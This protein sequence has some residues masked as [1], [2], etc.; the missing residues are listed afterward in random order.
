MVEVH[1]RCQFGEKR[2]SKGKLIRSGK[3]P[4]RASG[5]FRVHPVRGKPKVMFLCAECGFDKMPNHV[6]VVMP[7]ADAPPKAEPKY[8][9]DIERV[10]LL[11]TLGTKFDQA[12]VVKGDGYKHWVERTEVTPEAFSIA[13]V[14]EVK[15][16][17]PSMD[18]KA[19]LDTLRRHD[20]GK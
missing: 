11:A 15:S 8:F 10:E 14:K 7:P 12:K 20:D 16:R 18:L 6:Q 9:R 19:Y 1:I 4:N 2:D 5:I 13:P 3:C 17:I